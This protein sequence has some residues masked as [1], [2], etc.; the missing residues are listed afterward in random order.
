M[1]NPRRSKRFRDYSKHTS[2]ILFIEPAA[3]GPGSYEVPQS[4]SS[5]GSYFLS[6]YPSSKAI[7][8][9]QGKRGDRGLSSHPSTAFVNG[10][11]SYA[12]TWGL[13]SAFGVWTLRVEARSDLR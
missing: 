1:F 4:L 9:L 7:K 10:I 5:H 11:C 3:I 6:R 12:W 13:S 2:L 8:F